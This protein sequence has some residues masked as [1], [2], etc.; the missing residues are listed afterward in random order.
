MQNNNCIICGSDKDLETELTI[1]IDDQKITV[2][3]CSEHADDITPKAAKVAYLKWKTDY[4]ARMAEFLKQAAELG[5]VVAP[6]GSIMVAKAQQ[7]P[8]ATTT[9]PIVESQI[10]ELR[11]GRAEGILP[12]SE[13]DNVMQR[14]VSGLSGSVDGRG[15]EGHDAYNPNDLS[16]KLPDGARDGLVKMELAE[17]RHGTP[18]AIPSI[19]QDGLGTTRVRIAKTMTDA[20]LQRRFKRQASEDHSFVDGYDLHRCVMCNGEGQIKKSQ[21]ETIAC[22]KCG[23]SGL[24]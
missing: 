21:T 13:V 24:A 17:G 1:T 2:K 18:L 9:K 16:D 8:T 20:D 3:V 15:V 14:R 23:G 19:R 12:A 22:P 7:Q 4:D 6:Q 5:M 11:G 10:A